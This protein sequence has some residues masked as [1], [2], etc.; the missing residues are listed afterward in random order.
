M[1]GER[2]VEQAYIPDGDSA[3][4]PVGGSGLRARARRS[5]R[6][7]GALIRLLVRDPQH[8]PGAVDDLCGRSARRRRERVGEDVPVPGV[9]AGG[10][11]GALIASEA[12]DGNGDRDE[13]D[14]GW[15]GRDRTAEGC[16][17][18][19]S[20]SARFSPRTRSDRTCA[21]STASSESTLDSDALARAT[22]LGLLE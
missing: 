6:V 8:I 20:V 1:S 5:L 19:R 13:G 22:A 15:E 17:P 10:M 21:R 16:P 2:D 14:G 9:S 11:V 7:P 18:A 12:G 4:E 3:E